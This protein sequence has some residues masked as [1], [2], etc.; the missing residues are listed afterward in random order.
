MGTLTCGREWKVHTTFHG[1]YLALKIYSLSSWFEVFLQ[2]VFSFMHTVIVS[3]CPL[4]LGPRAYPWA[5]TEA[6]DDQSIPRGAYGVTAHGVTEG[7]TTVKVHTHIQAHM[8]LLRASKYYT[9][10]AFGDGE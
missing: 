3:W 10:T 2:A 8:H 6:D 7:S 4:C 9:E 1:N 5:T